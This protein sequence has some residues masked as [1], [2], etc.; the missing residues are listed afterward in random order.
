[1]N[2]IWRCPKCKK[3]L[4]LSNS[5]WKCIENHS[6]DI[7]KKGYVHLLLAN[8]KHQENSGDSKESME[9]RIRFLQHGF[10]QVLEHRLNE[11]FQHYLTKESPASFV[12]LACGEGNYT[13]KI[14]TS[15]QNKGFLNHTYGVDLS[16]SAIL[17]CGHK[18]RVQQ[19]TNIEFAIGNL[20]YLPILDQS[21]DIALNC[22]AKFFP[23]EFSRILKENGILIRVLPGRKHLWEMKEFLYTTPYENEL[24][25]FEGKEFH[26]IIEEE[27]EDHISLSQED[28]HDLIV[29]TPYF[30]KTNPNS[31]QKL[32][33]L[34]S[35]NITISF[36]IQVL[37]KSA[38]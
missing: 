1:M 17:S 3:P 12:D 28:I 14:H 6:Y 34:S 27:I 2:A 37:Q 30:Y 13:C 22:F 9:A 19:L 21:V 38:R 4:F 18:K 5:S 26:S 20:S 35:L 23:E 31:L 11:L 25:Y 36:H 10:Y 24:E 29:M 15:L 33:S 32:M 16:K 7:S 8:Q